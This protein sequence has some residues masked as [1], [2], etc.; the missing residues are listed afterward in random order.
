MGMIVAVLLLL[1]VAGLVYNILERVPRLP[2]AV[3]DWGSGGISDPRIAVASM[4]YA[5]ATENAR[6]TAEQERHILS[7][8]RS[9][10][11]LDPDAARTCLAAGRRVASGMRGDLNSRLH[12]LLIPVARKC[13][14]QEKQDVL[15]MLQMVAG[16]LAERLGP[17][18]EGLGRVSATLMQR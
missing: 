1:L 8:L 9:R 4:M 12:R 3:G 7:L 14:L 13:S 2:Q 18:R 17:V 6:L 16:P 11:G 15:E 10:I 5:V